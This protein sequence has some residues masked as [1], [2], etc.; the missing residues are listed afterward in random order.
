MRR[1]NWEKELPPEITTEEVIERISEAKCSSSLVK[2]TQ[3]VDVKKFE[4]RFDIALVSGYSYKEL[5]ENWKKALALLNL[6]GIIVIKGAWP[7]E[8]KKLKGD[9][10]SFVVDAF[11]QDGAEGCTIN[12]DGGISVFT[13]PKE[14][15]EETSTP[16]VKVRKNPH[17]IG[18]IDCCDVD[19]FIES[20]KRSKN[21]NR[22]N[23]RHSQCSQGRNSS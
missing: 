22:T 13:K 3:D 20:I 16:Y 17:L 7:W 5:K 1:I 12:S 11:A 15:G 10:Q 14:L 18:M 19:M 8:K 21:E 4:Q 2:I 6:N 9:V 23:I